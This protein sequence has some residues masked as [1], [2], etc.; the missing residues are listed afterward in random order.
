MIMK[1]TGQTVGTI[2]RRIAQVFGLFLG[3]LT[4]LSMAPY[5]IHVEA[6]VSVYQSDADQANNLATV[7]TVIGFAVSLVAAAFLVHRQHVRAPKQRLGA[8]TTLGWC[9]VLLLT[10]CVVSL[11]ENATFTRKSTYI[12]TATVLAD[13]RKDTNFD[14]QNAAQKLHDESI[15]LE[16]RYESAR[17]FMEDKQLAQVPPEK[18]LS[19]FHSAP[20]QGAIFITYVT[21]VLML[22]LG[23]FA[24]ASGL[25]AWSLQKK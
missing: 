4:T 7:L 1:K 10:I 15:S 22:R 9:G 24:L 12:A 13:E 2:L 17:Q 8:A 6:F 20:L 25:Y 19:G 11:L 3:V 18:V 5:P 16:E 21:T 14:A 23:L